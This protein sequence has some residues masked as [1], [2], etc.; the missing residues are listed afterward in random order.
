MAV[1]SA[2]DQWTKIEAIQ[3]R[4]WR[5]VD[6]AT[7]ANQTAQQYL[8]DTIN[9][10]YNRFSTTRENIA[11]RDR[12]SAIAQ[13]LLGVSHTNGTD[14]WNLV[15]RTQNP[16]THRDVFMGISNDTD[17]VT[18]LRCLSVR[19]L[20]SIRNEFSNGQ[21]MIDHAE[22]ANDDLVKALSLCGTFTLKN[23]TTNNAHRAC[24]SGMLIPG[25]RYDGT[26][27]VAVVPNG[28]KVHTCTHG[29]GI[30]TADN[31][32]L[33]LNNYYF[34]PY[35]LDLIDANAFQVQRVHCSVAGADNNNDPLSDIQRNK[36]PA[37]GYQNSDY[38]C[39][40]I[41]VTALGVP[42]IG[43]NRRTLREAFAYRQRN[44]IAGIVPGGADLF[45]NLDTNGNNLPQFLGVNVNYDQ[46]FNNT[47]QNHLGWNDT[48]LRYYSIIGRPGDSRLQ[49]NPS[50]FAVGI[51]LDN[52]YTSNPSQ[53]MR[54]DYKVVSPLVNQIQTTGSTTVRRRK[55]LCY[56]TY[57]GI[58][59]GIILQTY[60]NANDRRCRL[61]GT[62][63]GS[64]RV[65]TQGQNCVADLLAFASSIN[66]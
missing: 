38:A 50:G 59:G 36:N 65:F 14:F 8:I 41:S 5:R 16:F 57:P 53:F 42:A 27:H 60:S 12:L 18:Q 28:L 46:I 51:N 9:N 56:P 2:T 10:H 63:W 35:G 20:M 3:N 25:K 33:P 62:N 7:I 32:I 23:A 11:V 64:E 43:G 24:F 40:V 39:A 55:G 22:F 58:S 45:P 61:I 31:N 19:E 6:D 4:S 29:F 34:I 21:A 26:D 66:P 52:T 13:V 17:I 49:F 37:Y 48:H 44:S 15:D 30:K 1:I 54:V 47:F